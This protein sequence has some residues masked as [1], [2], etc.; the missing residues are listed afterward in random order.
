MLRTSFALLHHDAESETLL[1]NFK[2]LLVINNVVFNTESIIL[3]DL[4]TQV[5]IQLAICCEEP[6]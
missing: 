4:S 3:L 6:L 2:G 5:K 1:C